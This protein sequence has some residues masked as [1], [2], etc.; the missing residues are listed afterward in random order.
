MSIICVKKEREVLKK[1]GG[2][3]HQKI[4]VSLFPTFFGLFKCEK[5][6]SEQGKTFYDWSILESKKDKNLIVNKN[7]IFPETNNGIEN[8]INILKS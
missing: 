4:G 3:C 2:G 7:E 6:E 1:Y 5:G 8:I